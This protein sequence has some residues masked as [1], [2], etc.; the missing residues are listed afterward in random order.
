[1]L[2]E[3]RAR[4]TLG[5]GRLSRIDGG[6][7]MVGKA[8]VDVRHVELDVCRLRF[9]SLEHSRILSLRAGAVRAASLLM[10]LAWSRLILLC[11]RQAKD[12]V[13]AG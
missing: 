9:E 12:R 10:E 3:G 1:M 8:A 11:V 4:R 7:Q 2:L 5:K 13:E 6:K